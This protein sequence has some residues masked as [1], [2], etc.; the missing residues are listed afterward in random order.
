MTVV[1]VVVVNTEV[2]V[3]GVVNKKVVVGGDSYK[4]NRVGLFA[5]TNTNRQCTHWKTTTTGTART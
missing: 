4:E 3:G 2:V 1:V 5:T